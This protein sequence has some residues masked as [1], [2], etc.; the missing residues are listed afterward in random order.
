M[1]KILSIAAMGLMVLASSQAFGQNLLANPGFEDPV[2]SDGYPFAGSWEAFSGGAGASAGNSS[3]T[4]R[5]GA[6]DV[7]LSI[8][9]T[10]NTFAGVF[11]DVPGL[12]AGQSVTFSGFHMSPSNP[13]DL[14][15]EIRIEWRSN[16]NNDPTSVE[17]SRTGN[18]NP[19]AGA[20]SYV[21]FSLNAN[22]PAGAT[23]ARVVYAIQTFSG[24]PT[25]N[26]IVF[27][28]DFSVT[29]P[30]PS[31]IAMIGVGLVGL[32]GLRRPRP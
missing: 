6:Q 12:T 1:R 28:D 3:T 29:V 20:G 18:L 22:V 24:G 4:P 10:D 17:I 13:L 8:A 5:S 27:L 21:P 7:Q 2:T 25:N 26:G 32:G 14:T 30:E 16:T 19:V 23:V 15:S 9:N 31:T 11:Q